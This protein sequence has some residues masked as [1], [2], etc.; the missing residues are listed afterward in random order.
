ML[1]S[2][3]ADQSNAFLIAAVSPD[4]TGRFNA[5]EIA[6]EIAGIMGGSGGGRPDMAQAGGKN[7][8][9]LPE[10][11]DRVYQIAEKERS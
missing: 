5:G 9:K 4:L 6:K 8:S 11:L 7:V 10:A 3:S 1:A 2:A